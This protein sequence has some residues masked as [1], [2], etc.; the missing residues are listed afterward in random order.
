MPSPEGGG[1][2]SAYAPM[3]MVARGPQGGDGQAR[4]NVVAVGSAAMMETVLV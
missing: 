4:A 2:I 3:V 1:V